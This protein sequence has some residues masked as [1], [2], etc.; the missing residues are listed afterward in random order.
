[1]ASH[2][3]EW[4]VTQHKVTTFIDKYE[5]MLKLLQ[6]KLKKEYLNSDTI[7]YCILHRESLCKSALNLKHVTD[8]IVNNVNTIRARALNHH[9]LQLCLIKWRQ[10]W[11]M[12][13]IT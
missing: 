4:Q 11:Q 12:L 13:F 6:D 10:S 8:P 1:M 5:G 9:N 2:S 3:L 7:F